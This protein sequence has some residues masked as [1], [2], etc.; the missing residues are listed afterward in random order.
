MRRS[1]SQGCSIFSGSGPARGGLGLGPKPDSS[2]GVGRRAAAGGRRPGARPHTRHRVTPTCPR[3]MCIGGARVGPAPPQSHPSMHAM[4]RHRDAPRTAGV[5]P[6]I[7]VRSPS[8]KL[9]RVADREPLQTW[10][11]LGSESHWQSTPSTRVLRTRP[12][13]GLLQLARTRG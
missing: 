7:R 13:S 10:T 3:D 1:R 4:L 9:H 8:T 6:S 12:E 5:P 11:P 2:G